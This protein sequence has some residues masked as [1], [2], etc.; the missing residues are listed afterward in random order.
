MN[1]MMLAAAFALVAGMAA[2][3]LAQGVWQTQRND[4]G[5]LAHVEIAPCGEKLCG[6]MIRS[7][8]PDNKPMD[9]PNIGRNLVWDM[10]SRGGGAYANGQIWDPG[11]DRTYRSKMELSGD[12]LKVSGCVAGGLICR[13]QTWLRVN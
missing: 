7:F 5:N 9:S 2:A 12:R 13:G 4:D 1:K 3:D 10:E 11:A 6:T 8:G